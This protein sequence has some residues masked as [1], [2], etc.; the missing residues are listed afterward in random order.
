MSPHLDK[1]KSR[2]ARIEWRI[3]CCDQIIRNAALSK[4]E[5]AV[6]AE[7]RATLAAERELLADQITAIEAFETAK[8]EQLLT[9]N[10]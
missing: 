6:A 10:L 8:R 9:E 1:L 3:G 5:I 4:S 7:D 2:L